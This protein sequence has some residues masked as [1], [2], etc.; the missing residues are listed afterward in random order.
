MWC[1]RRQPWTIE[2]ALDFEPRTV[3]PNATGDL[4]AVVGDVDVVV[5]HLPALEARRNGHAGPR[6]CGYVRLG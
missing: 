4:L 2:P 6:A 1:T 3:L 5:L